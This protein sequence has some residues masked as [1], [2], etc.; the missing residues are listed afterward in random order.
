[1]QKQETQQMLSFSAP[2]HKPDSQIEKVYRTVVEFPGLRTT[3]L[4]YKANAL[5]GI[6][7]GAFDK[8]LRDLQTEQRIKGLRINDDSEKS[9][10]PKGCEPC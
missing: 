6:G 2:V 8:R 9:W 5:H 10:F 4:G 3:L 1:M 7:L